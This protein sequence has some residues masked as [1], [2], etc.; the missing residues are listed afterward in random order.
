MTVDT[1]FMREVFNQDMKNSRS[2]LCVFWKGDLPAQK[3][4]R[5]V[6]VGSTGI[7]WG[8]KLE[9]RHANERTH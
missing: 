2:L 6:A 5:K 4:L 7:F 9:C 8:T 1:N 3:K